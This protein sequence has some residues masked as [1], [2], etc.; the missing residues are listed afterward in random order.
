MQWDGLERVVEVGAKV[1][2]KMNWA[3]NRIFFFIGGTCC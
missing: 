1:V 3:E 2:R